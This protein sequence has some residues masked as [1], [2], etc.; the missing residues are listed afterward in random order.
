LF[1]SGG[2]YKFFR[3]KFF[4]VYKFV[5]GFVMDSSEFSDVKS[6]A[7]TFSILDE[8]GDENFIYDVLVK[9]EFGIL[10]SGSKKFYNTDK[11]ISLSEWVKN[12]K[13]PDEFP[14]FKS[15]LSV[16]Y[17]NRSVGMPK[18]SLGTLVI[19][20]NNVSN[21]QNCVFLLTGGI[22]SRNGKIYLD[23]KNFIKSCMI[24]T[25]RT[26]VVKSY[27]NGN[28]EF[29][30][31]DENDEKLSS[32]GYDS[33]VYSIFNNSSQ[34]S[35]LRQIEYKNKLWDIKNEFFWMSKNE[36]LEL[37]NQ[38]NYSDLYNDARTDSDRY[39][40]KL[41]F[42]EERIYDKL[43]PDAKLVLDK[44]TELVIKS[45]QMREIFANDENHLKSWDAGYAQLKLLWK[46]YYADDFKEFRQLYK[47]LEDRMRPLVY[48]LGFLLK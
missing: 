13:K 17:S 5:K 45:M 42:G 34:Q 46:E 20:G 1:I 28:D 44:A 36:M 32:Y 31:P 29:L 21:S 15:A 9:N 35:S 14:T 40:H 6:W 37:S 23:E 26:C 43:S 10:T 4:K 22:T 11:K 39:V 25:S 47:N 30:A 48:E 18:D 2:S 41:L 3:Q 27:L 38:N 33:V 19:G 12:T 24:F 8:Y 7:L 16:H